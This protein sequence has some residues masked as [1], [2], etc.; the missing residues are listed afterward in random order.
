MTTPALVTATCLLQATRRAARAVTAAYE[1]ALAP[2]NLTASQ[3]STLMAVAAHDPFGVGLTPLAEGLGLDRTTLTR[4]LAPMERRGLLELGPD[5]HDARARVAKL[6][7]AGRQL[8]PEAMR[9]WNTA[10]T[11]VVMRLGPLEAGLRPGLAA[12]ST[13]N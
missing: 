5:P 1:Q 6:G 4:V 8:I 3:F 10:Q 13:I 11:R 7:D 9:L 12:L 2:V